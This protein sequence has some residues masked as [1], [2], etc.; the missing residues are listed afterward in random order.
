M[1]QNCHAAAGVCF[2]PPAKLLNSLWQTGMDFTLITSIK[3]GHLADMGLRC[4]FQ[5]SHGKHQAKNHPWFVLTLILRKSEQ[6][7]FGKSPSRFSRLRLMM[8]ETALNVNPTL[9]NSCGWH[10]GWNVGL[11]FG[12]LCQVNCWFP[13][14]L[15][16]S[17]REYVWLKLD[18]Q[19]HTK[20]KA[21]KQN[22]WIQAD[23]LTGEKQSYTDLHLSSFNANQISHQHHDC[24]M[25]P[26][27]QCIH[28]LMT[29]SC[30]LQKKVRFCCV[31]T[32]QG[33]PMAVAMPL[34]EWKVS[35]WD[36]G[37]SGQSLWP[38]FTSKTSTDLCRTCG[39]CRTII[40]QVIW[41]K[42]RAVSHVTQLMHQ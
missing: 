30:S 16:V 40:S 19:D 31:Y 32:R 42:S 21:L 23:S 38:Q 25:G 1:N 20:E 33:E 5:Q 29:L 15:K 11:R 36:P 6:Q 10:Y 17:G 26:D 22:K 14:C 8:V 35:S 7:S 24:D 27:S 28:S 37:W 2:C 34:Q 4:K 3:L 9:L 18:S 41:L 13:G 39:T 12:K